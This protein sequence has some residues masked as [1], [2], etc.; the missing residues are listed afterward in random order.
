MAT[1]LRER[2][3]KHDGGFLRR[4]SVGILL[5]DDFKPY[6][7]FVTSLVADSPD[8]RI[9]GEA[10]DGLEAIERAQQLKPDMVLMDMGLPK[11]N[12]LT[13]A[14]RICESAPSAKIVF[15]TQETSAEVVKEALSLGAWGYIVKKDAGTDLLAGLEAILQGERFVSSTVA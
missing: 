10:S 8:L 7:D 14:R 15:L 5:V 2:V 9:V 4:S 3:L 6:R 1:L 13:A 11:L 12:G